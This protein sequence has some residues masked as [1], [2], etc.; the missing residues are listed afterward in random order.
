MAEILAGKQDVQDGRHGG[1]AE[2][3]LSRHV[4]LP[5][6]GGP[7]RRPPRGL[8][9][10]GHPLPLQAHEGLQRPSPDGLGRL[11]PPRRAVRRG[12]R[13]AP[14]DHHEE[15]RG[16]LPPAD[17]GARLQLRLGPRGQHDRS[18]VL[19]V[20]A[21]DLRTALQEGARLRRRSARELVPRPRHGSRERGGDRRPL[22][23]R[24]PSRDPPPDAPVDAAHHRLRRKAARGARH[25]RL[26]RG[27]QGDAAQLDREVRGGAGGVSG[28]EGR[29]LGRPRTPA[30][31]CR[32]GRGL[33]RPRTPSQG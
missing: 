18:Q 31:G 16:P 9:G 21:V 11:R 8:Y 1:Q 22:G 19:Q 29:G 3:L 32:N 15:E 5:V 33:G 4:P 30:R 14:R 2:V 12:D 24:Q 25:A 10:D 27:H 20:D 13:H 17:P 28:G 23:T 26:A 7:S 6:G